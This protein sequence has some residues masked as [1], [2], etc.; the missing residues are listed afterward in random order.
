MKLNPMAVRLAVLKH[1]LFNTPDLIAD[2][3]YYHENRHD[4]CLSALVDYYE[5]IWRRD[6]PDEKIPYGPAC[7]EEVAS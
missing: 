7:Y 6:R 2:A 1:Y 3:Q 5:Y 4:L